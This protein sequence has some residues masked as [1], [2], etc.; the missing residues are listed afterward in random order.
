MTFM[1]TTTIFMDSLARINTYTIATGLPHLSGKLIR[2]RWN[3]KEPS[4]ALSLSLHGEKR[5]SISPFVLIV[6]DRGEPVDF[7]VWLLSL[8]LARFSSIWIG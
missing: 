3:R 7:V 8:K 6:I 1:I 2:R 5:I 4:H